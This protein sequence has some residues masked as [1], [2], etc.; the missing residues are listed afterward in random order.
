LG[1]W[2]IHTDNVK[3]MK[4]VRLIRPVEVRIERIFRPESIKDFLIQLTLK[5]LMLR[6]PNQF[7]V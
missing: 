3:D 2:D 7:Q 5:F 1:K 4:R 6:T